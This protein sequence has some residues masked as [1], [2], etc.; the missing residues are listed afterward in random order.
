[1]N[2]DL[3]KAL[4]NVSAV[5]LSGG[6]VGKVCLVLIVVSISIGSLAAFSGNAWIVGAGIGAIFLLAFPM[7]WRLIN[8]A[9]RN[10]Q[11]A[12]LEGA[13]FLVH[14]QILLGT[15][16]NPT[17]TLDIEAITEERPA[18]L[19]GE[20]RARLNEPDDAQAPPPASLD[21]GRG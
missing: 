11:A 14:Q 6:V 18:E 10:P 19:Q 9:D 17:M 12:L 7:L 15:K 3:E 16:A 1:M 4:Q 5:K 21:G 8:F 13:E 2:F 20:E